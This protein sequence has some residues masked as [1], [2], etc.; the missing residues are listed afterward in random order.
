MKTLKILAMAATAVGSGVLAY[1]PKAD[2]SDLPNR[3][4]EAAP[5][6]TSEAQAFGPPFED[7]WKTQ[8]HPGQCKSCHAKI[9]DEWN[10]SMMSNAWRDPVW[11]AAFLL[12]ARTVSTHGDCDAPSPPDGTKRAATNPFAKPGACASVFD[13]GTSKYTVSRPGS[14]LD[15]F[16]S[17]CHMPTNYI[18]NVPLRNVTLDPVTGIESAKA[19]PAFNPTSDN[20][21]GSAF[22]TVDAQFRNTDSGKAG[23]FC[24][25]CHSFVATRDTPFHNYVRSGAEYVAAPGEGGRHDLLGDRQDVFA[26]ADPAKRNLGY[27]IG[28]G[29]YRLSAHAIGAPERFGP[30]AAG[31]PPD[32]IDRNTSSVFGVDVPYQHMDASKH[33]GFHDAM[34]VRAEMCG[35]CH[36]VTNALPIKNQLGQWVGGFPIERTY[37]EWTNSRYADRPGNTKFDPRFKRDCQSCHMQQDYGQPGTAQTLYEHG[38]PLPPPVEPVATGGA[39]HPFFTHHFVG[40]NALVPRLIGKDLDA[41]GAS[42]P[43]PELANVSFSSGDRSSPY[44]RAVWTHVERKGAYAQQARLAWERLRHVLS[45]DVVAPATARSGGVVPLTITIANTGSG[46]DFPTGFPEGRIA[47][48]AVHAY[49]LATGRE[50]SI[51]DSV[52]HRTSIGVGNLTA[53]AALDP[54]YPR[55]DWRLP[56]GSADP[57]AIQFKAVA[58]LG[59]GCPTLELPYASPLNLA[60]NADG[61]PI[62]AAGRVIE[63]RK[64]PGGLPVFEDKNGNGDLFDDSFLSDTRLKPMPWPDA[65]RRVD[66]Y[67]VVVPAG[68]AGPIAVSAAVYYQ[69]VEAVVA[70]EF[71]GNL[72]DTNGDLVLQPCVLGGPCDGRKPSTEP[73]VVEGAPPVP[74]VAR[75]ALIAVDGRSG[76][77]DGPRLS[78]YPLDG[79]ARA[80]G[81]TVVKVFASEPA[82]GVDAATFTLSDATGARVPAHVDQIGSAAWGLFPDAITLTPGGTYTARVA[83]GVCDVAGRC[84]RQDRSWRFTVARDGETGA[85]DTSLPAAFGR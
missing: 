75:D 68:T 65:T 57:Y 77:P 43:Y 48:L 12:L 24:A 76:G 70:L 53:Q 62:D 55:C 21:T 85:G 37:T 36:D 67:A 34:F 82:V 2:L 6:V 69:S 11:R 74:M 54:S 33:A 5:Y 58:S 22:A 9:F 3:I 38:L 60:K 49:D 42:S 46:H 1:E 52:W 27:G 28:S 7:Y 47:W 19:D 51:D 50:L 17:R 14:L 64:N 59:D 71:L 78:V 39:P 8:D 44:S 45:M 73:P 63:A 84:T 26:V 10:G 15:A 61:L 56:A 79:A 4:P 18:D 13:I 29:S 30:L 41:S 32:P 66:R 72:T 23:I 31:T 25:V 35:S 20:G 16:C 40:G 83:R 80:Y 81:D